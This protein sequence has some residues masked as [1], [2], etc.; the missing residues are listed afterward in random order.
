[1]KNKLFK[2]KDRAIIF[3][4]LNF[5]IFILFLMILIKN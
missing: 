2:A 1:M 3:A 4:D 5:S